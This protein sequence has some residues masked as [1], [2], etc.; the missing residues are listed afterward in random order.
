MPLPLKSNHINCF[1]KEILCAILTVAL[2]TIQFFEC[3]T[4]GVG[5]T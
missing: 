1:S 5:T 2:A 4:V 3:V